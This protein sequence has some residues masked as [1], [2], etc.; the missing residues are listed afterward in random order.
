MPGSSNGH[1]VM[2]GSLQ[3]LPPLAMSCCFECGD[4]GHIKRFCPHLTGGSSQQR[5]QPLASAPIT[6]P[7]AQSARD[8]DAM[9]TCIVSFCRRD[10]SVLFDPGF[11]FS[12]V[13]S[14]FARYLDTPCE[15]LVSSVHVSTPVCDTIVVDRVYRSCVVNIGSLEARVDLLLLCI[16]DFDVISGK[17]WLSPCHG[18]L[19]YHAKIVTLAMR[20]V[21]RIEWH[22]STD[23]VRSRVI[24][25]LKA[26]RM[27]GKGCL[28]YLEFLRDVG[29]QTPS[30]D[31]VPIVRDFPEIFP[32]DLPGMT[33]DMDIDFGID[34]VPDTHPISIPPYRMAPTELK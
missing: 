10:A 28:S 19:D 11:T 22:G 24:S 17:D 27:V 1:P 7:P 4:L 34:M 6:S 31:Y 23:F 13:L 21:P 15:S 32:A 12:Y 5:S 2:R 3:P 29:A 18:I 16:V 25:F 20:D 33:V 9:I 8:G 26:Q 14:Y 30:I